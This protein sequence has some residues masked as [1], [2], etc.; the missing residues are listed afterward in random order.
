MRLKKEI[1]VWRFL[2]GKI[3]H[4]KQ[5]LALVNSL[6]LEIK[7][8]NI[9]ITNLIITTFINIRKLTKFSRPDLIIGVGHRVH[10]SL[11]VAKFL[12]GGKSI[13]IMKPSIP[14]HWFDLCIIPKHDQYNGK[15]LVYRTNGALCD[16]KNK[17]KK[18][19]TKGLILIGGLS[20]DFIWNED[21]VVKQ[22]MQL[23]INNPKIKFE[24][25]TSRRTPIDFSLNLEILKSNLDKLSLNYKKNLKISFSKNQN[26]NWV[27]ERMSEAKFAWI[28][29]DSISMICESLTAG[30]LVGIIKLSK[31]NKINKKSNSLDILKKD[32][33]IFYDQDGTYK[34]TNKLKIFPNQAKKCANWIKK[35]FISDNQLKINK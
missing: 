8:L 18:K 1:I 33:F 5:S 34:N 28:T 30:Q 25:T 7:L 11:L 35:N 15:G 32:G 12:F 29:E 16:I 4:E 19:S 13:V 3:G 9:P 24:L 31:K 22:I 14:V 10:I 20:K 21:S 6:D 23:V 17:S 26:K 27:K 2:D